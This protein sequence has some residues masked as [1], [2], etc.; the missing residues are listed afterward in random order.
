MRKRR[1]KLKVPQISPEAMTPQMAQ[2]VAFAKQLVKSVKEARA[3]K[4]ALK[5]ERARLLRARRACARR[6]K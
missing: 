4:Q 5:A 1:R 2:L 3:E 6:P